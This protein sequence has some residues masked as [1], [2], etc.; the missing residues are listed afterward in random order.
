M[1]WVL[2]LPILALPHLAAAQALPDP[3]TVVREALAQ[4]EDRCGMA[5]TRPSDYVASLSEVPSEHLMRAENTA[6]GAILHAVIL[7]GGALEQVKMF[8]LPGRMI[9][10][11]SVQGQN[12][13]QLQPIATNPDALHAYSRQVDAAIVAELGARAGA[14]HVRAAFPSDFFSANLGET[15]GMTHFFY[16][17]TLPLGGREQFSFAENE[18]GVFYFGAQG[19]VSTP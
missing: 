9:V 11:C 7:R 8:G 17:I 16:G 10:I 12:L 13:M 15:P 18:G 2:A 6:D 5:T 1:R 4:F 3:S 19:E 14:T